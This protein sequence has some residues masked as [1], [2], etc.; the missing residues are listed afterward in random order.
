MMAAEA[1]IWQSKMITE[2]H[3]VAWGRT[4]QPHSSHGLSSRLTSQKKWLE[5]KQFSATM[6]KQLRFKEAAWLAQETAAAKDEGKSQAML[7]AMLQEQQDR[8][9]VAMAAT[10]RSTWLQ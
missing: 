9:I 10:R 6:T 1:Q 2:D 4:R 5:S 3:M 7:L 8:Q